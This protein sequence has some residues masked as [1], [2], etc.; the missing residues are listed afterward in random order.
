M[1]RTS[2]FSGVVFGSV[3]LRDILWVGNDNLVG[4]NAKDRTVLIVE[5]SLDNLNVTFV[6]VPHEPC[7]RDRRPERSGNVGQRMECAGVDGPQGVVNHS[8]DRGIEREPWFES[9]DIG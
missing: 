6:M 4:S 5:D 8:K 2:P 7:S 1:V 9:Q 3:Y